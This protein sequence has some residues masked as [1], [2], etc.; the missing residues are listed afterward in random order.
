MA[1]VRRH[2]GAKPFVCAL[3]LPRQ[4]ERNF[5]QASAGRVGVPDGT[6]QYRQTIEL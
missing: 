1:A 2:M 4:E 3:A 5:F 6:W